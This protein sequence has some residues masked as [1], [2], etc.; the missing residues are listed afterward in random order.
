MIK[1][2]TVILILLLLSPIVCAFESATGE[3]VLKYDNDSEY[4][5]YVP[6]TYSGTDTLPLVM[7]LHGAGDNHFKFFKKYNKG[8]I[9]VFA[10]QYK[11]LVACPQGDPS[12]GWNGPG[13]KDFQRVFQNVKMKYRVDPKRCYLL[14]HSMGGGAAIYFSIKYPNRFA[15]VAVCAPSMAEPSWAPYLKKTPLYIAHGSDDPIVSVGFIKRFVDAL[16]DVDAPLTYY[17]IPGADHNNYVP[18]QF[19]PI[20]E[21]FQDKKLK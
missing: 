15:A 13:E 2:I 14:G 3:L 11:M 19:G 5:L 1:S 21:W 7:A 17:E 16:K 4:C 20:F 8:I 6:T 9:K 12:Y 18:D 10:E